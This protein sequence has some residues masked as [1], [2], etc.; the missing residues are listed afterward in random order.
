M[1]EKELLHSENRDKR[2]RERMGEATGKFEVRD[3]AKRESD[4]VEC[5]RHERRRQEVE[6]VERERWE[7]RITA[8]QKS[9]Q[10][11]RIEAGRVA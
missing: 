3:E 1:K 8:E 7:V 9:E 6:R 2:E 11:Q 10:A 5:E 4:N